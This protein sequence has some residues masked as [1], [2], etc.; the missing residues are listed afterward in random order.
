MDILKS[1]FN[2]IKAEDELKE[3]T[4]AFVRKMISNE[5]QQKTTSSSALLLMKEKSSYR[6][7]V[8]VASSIAACAIF[9]FGGFAFYNTPVNYISFDVNPSVEIGLNA[10]D[11]VVSLEAFNEDGQALLIS[12][13]LMH[14]SFDVVIDSLVQELNAQK[15]IFSDGSTVIAVTALSNDENRAIAI[16]D[17]SRERI[18]QV[19]R[20]RNLNAVIY[21]DYANL[22]IRTEAR[23]NG[24]SPGKFKLIST[25]Q[26]L[27]PTISI[28]QYRD[29]K[30]TEIIVK[31]NEL[32]LLREK[33]GLS[34]LALETAYEMISITASRIEKA[35]G[36]EIQAQKQNLNPDYSEQIQT[37]NEAQIQ[38]Q[39]QNQTTTPAQIQTQN[40]AQIQTQNQNQTTTPSQIQTN[41]ETQTQTQ[42]QNQT[43]TPAQIQT[44]TETQTKN[45]AQNPQ[46]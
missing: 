37:Q 6:K 11:A 13:R 28:D 27:D 5:G 18:E 40:E 35:S 7:F 9:A 25:L 23:E 44:N 29:T 41:T 42:N 30:V 45:E 34:T 33:D 16:R 22:S 10:F 21:S 43:T 8:V 4:K 38:T 36:N 20:E 39:N 19:L 1:Y 14:K 26:N 32:L 2:K 17:R 12:Q 46:N 3:N 15:Y 31:A 24:V